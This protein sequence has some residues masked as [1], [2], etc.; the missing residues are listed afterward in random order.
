MANQNGGQFD[1]QLFGDYREPQDS[2]LSNPDLDDFFNDALDADFM[3]PYNL[4]PAATAAAA[5][6]S[7][8]EAA[9][10]VSEA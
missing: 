1:P 7:S 4:P 9:R 10:I 2:L 3:T 8:S 5:A 6:H